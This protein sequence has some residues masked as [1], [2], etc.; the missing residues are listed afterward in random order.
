[1][2]LS[3]SEELSVINRAV[4]RR[5]R[6]YRRLM[7]R[8]ES[9]VAILE[10]ALVAIPF[11]FI[12]YGLITFGMILAL[13]QSVTNASAEAARSAVGAADFSTAATKAKASAVQRLGWLGSK[14]NANDAAQFTTEEV[15]CVASSGA[16]DCIKVTIAYQ[17][18]DNPL[19]PPAPGLGLFV[20]S[21]ISSQSTVKFK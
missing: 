6:P 19:V 15:D 7:R 2:V 17:Y 10:F 13:K 1:M 12:L 9:G 20:P 11:F 21:Q 16:K 8:D 18:D 3:T 5:T 14:F 4:S